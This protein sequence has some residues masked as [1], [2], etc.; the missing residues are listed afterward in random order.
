MNFTNKI[1]VSINI[2][3][4]KCD[5]FLNK[6]LRSPLLR[7]CPFIFLNWKSFYNRAEICISLLLEYLWLFVFSGICHSCLFSARVRICKIT[8]LYLVV[9]FP[10]PFS[11]FLLLSSSSKAKINRLIVYEEYLFWNKYISYQSWSNVFRFWFRII[12]IINLKTGNDLWIE[13]LQ[14]ARCTS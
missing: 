3:E 12:R 14:S 6:Y 13:K 4:G 8:R 5:N 1:Y 11:Y 9:R 7:H 2:S 10:V